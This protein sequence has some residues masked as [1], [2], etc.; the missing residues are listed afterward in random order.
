M[1]RLLIKFPNDAMAAGTTFGRHLGEIS[2]LGVSMD[3]IKGWRA[4]GPNEQVQQ[5]R[6]AVGVCS[7]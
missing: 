1:A 3:E 7:F 5:W 4:L 6:L 2:G